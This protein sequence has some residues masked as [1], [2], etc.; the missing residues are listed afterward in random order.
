MDLSFQAASVHVLHEP[1]LRTLSFVKQEKQQHASSHSRNR[2]ST[3]GIAGAAWSV[4]PGI[5]V[6]YV[7]S[8]AIWMNMRTLITR[9]ALSRIIQARWSGKPVQ[10]VVIPVQLM[11]HFILIG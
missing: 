11:G 1:W 3:N 2:I 7:H 6:H 10:H 5:L 8:K 9:A 4:V